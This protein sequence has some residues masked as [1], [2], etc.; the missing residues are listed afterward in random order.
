MHKH[1]LKVQSINQTVQ[2]PTDRAHG[3]IC[4]D[5]RG[6][7]DTMNVNKMTATGMHL[8]LG[9]LSLGGFV[10]ER[11]MN[12]GNYS[13][14]RNGGFDQGVQFLISAN[15]KLKMPGRDTL[16]FE[17][18][19]GV[20]GEF[21]NFGGEVLEDGGGVDCRR[22]SDTLAGGYGA[23]EETVYTTNGKLVIVA[24]VVCEGYMTLRITRTC[25]K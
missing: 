25:P 3:R 24:V 17:I 14:S 15:G 7:D 23:L 22:C 18:L 12:V 11:F 16:H 21:E 19:A 5:E 9:L 20:S 10:N 1:S 13:S 6:R 2:S 8:K 4:R